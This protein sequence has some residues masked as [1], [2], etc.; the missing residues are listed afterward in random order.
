MNRNEMAD[1][2]RIMQAQCT[3]HGAQIFFS[4]LGEV[5][6]AYDPGEAS[7]TISPAQLADLVA[8]WHSTRP[9]A[10]DERRQRRVQYATTAKPISGTPPTPAGYESLRSILNRAFDQAAF[11]K[12]AE[13]HANQKPFEEQPMQRLCDAYGVG[14]ALGQAGKKSEECQQLQHDAQVKELLGAIVYLAGS[15]LYLERKKAANDNSSL[16]AAK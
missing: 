7:T 15:I 12:G 5:F 1:L 8:D 13:R 4:D 6:V 3:A 16:R 9:T 2:F 14:F 10:T 11:G